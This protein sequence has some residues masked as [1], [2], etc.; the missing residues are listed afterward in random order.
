[1]APGNS[2]EIVWDATQVVAAMSNGCRVGDP[3]PV[4]PGSYRVTFGYEL[5]PPPGC[6]ADSARPDLYYCPERPG[7]AEGQVYAPLCP[8]GETASAQ[9]VLPPPSTDPEAGDSVLVDV[10]V[11]GGR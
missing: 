3:V 10:A 7:L 9:F 2:W 8:T 1:M 11:N 5:S 4:A 6:A